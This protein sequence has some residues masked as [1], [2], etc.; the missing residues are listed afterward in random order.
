[1]EAM[2][3][4]CKALSET[5]VTLA[6]VNFFRCIQRTRF[7]FHISEIFLLISTFRRKI[8][9]TNERLWIITYFPR[10]L[11]FIDSVP[12]ASSAF[13]SW[14]LFNIF[15]HSACKYLRILPPIIKISMRHRKTIESWEKCKV[16][17]Y[18]S[19][20]MQSFISFFDRPW[21][22]D[23]IVKHFNGLSMFD[24][25][26]ANQVVPAAITK[27]CKTFRL[28]RLR[29]PKFWLILLT[30]IMNKSIFGLLVYFLWNFMFFRVINFTGQVLKS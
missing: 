28:L 30:W 18:F 4:P 26:H 24:L 15:F 11:S 21:N 20:F 16:S 1:M 29:N 2:Y 5:N 9:S 19:N 12:I 7:A 22:Y 10:L 25:L 17:L 6:S 27:L 14:N 23:L 8:V 13:T 3:I